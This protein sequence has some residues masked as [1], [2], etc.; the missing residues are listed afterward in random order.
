MSVAG[1][2]KSEKSTADSQAQRLAADEDPT[3][4]KGFHF[5]RPSRTQITWII[6]GILAAVGVGVAL[7]IWR[8]PVAEFM[9][10]I[11]DQETV[12]A[13]LQSFGWW[14]P[15][16]L[17]FAQAMQVL[18]AFIPGH[19]FLIAAGYVY[20]FPLGLLLN[21]TFTVAASQ[22]CFLLA[23]WAG[24]PV[25]NRF[26]DPLVVDRWERIANEKGILFFTISFWLPVFPSDAMNFVAG[27]SG[28]S[29]R[30]FLVANIL[31][32]IPSAIMLTLIGSHGLEL[33]RSAWTII[34]IIAVAVFFLGRYVFHK[35]QQSTL[36]S[37]ATSPTD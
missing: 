33:P 25:V 21:L 37:M 18:F 15:A 2:S 8:E 35:M 3:Q 36:G 14:G 20:G 5:A 17:A 6:L 27:L 30:R 9:A 29:S 31:G 34:A 7:W 1:E 28:I 4:A 13:Y 12:S 11:R 26:V 32:R 22:L 19:V 24:R 23:R 10:L 16:V